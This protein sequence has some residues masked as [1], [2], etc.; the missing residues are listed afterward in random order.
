MRDLP[1]Y[2]R[3]AD[4]AKLVR[5]FCKGVCCKGRWAQMNEDYPG[6]DVLKSAPLGQFTATCLVCGRVALDNYNWIR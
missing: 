1:D 3:R 5:I 4:P 6:E 2:A